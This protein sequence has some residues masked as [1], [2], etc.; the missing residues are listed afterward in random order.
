MDIILKPN[1][2]FAQNR[3]R[4]RSILRFLIC[5]ALILRQW[6]VKLQKWPKSKHFVNVVH[7][8]HGK[9]SEAKGQLCAE[10]RKKVEIYWSFAKIPLAIFFFLTL[11]GKS[12]WTLKSHIMYELHYLQNIK[13]SGIN[14]PNAKTANL[15]FALISIY[16]YKVI[17]H[18]V[19]H[20]ILYKRSAM[21][22][23]PFF[24]TVYNIC[25]TL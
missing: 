11:I 17:S 4:C 10:H 5:S 13:P 16:W 21:F 15:I 14:K 19:V 1:G 3:S 8:T 24:L 12:I 20:H 23:N 18:F 22:P 7:R 25:I 9:Y 2:S 6:P